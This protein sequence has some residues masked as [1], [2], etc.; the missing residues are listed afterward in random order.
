MLIREAQRY[1]DPRE[2]YREYDVAGVKQVDLQ[3]CG[4][5]SIMF[6]SRVLIGEAKRHDD[7]ENR[8]VNVMSPA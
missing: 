8:T 7:L 2:M 3:P 1:D 4:L 5:Y 6:Y